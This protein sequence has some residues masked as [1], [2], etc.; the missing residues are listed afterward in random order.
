[1]RR[2]FISFHQSP[3]LFI[4]SLLSTWIIHSFISLACC[5]TTHMLTTDRNILF[6]TRL[7]SSH[8]RPCFCREV[9]QFK[10]T[11]K[12]YHTLSWGA[13]P[14]VV[15]FKA[16]LCSDLS[17]LTQV[18]LWIEALAHWHTLMPKSEY[19]A[20][21]RWSLPW[22]CRLSGECWGYTV[23]QHDT[24]QRLSISLHFQQ[25]T[26]C[27]CVSVCVFGKGAWQTSPSMLWKGLPGFYQTPLLELIDSARQGGQP[28]EILGLTSVHVLCWSLV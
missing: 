16:V 23:T 24:T 27:V 3:L 7:L 12:T 13:P 20:R 18:W 26:C 9:L 22:C 10:K 14:T 15:Q 6:H 2:L 11:Q 19:S 4:F 17:G 28:K 1:M 25:T 8:H 21:F 5:L